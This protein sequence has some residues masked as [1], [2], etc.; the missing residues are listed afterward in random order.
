VRNIIAET[1]D[2]TFPVR[3]V[4]CWGRWWRRYLRSFKENRTS[5]RQ[6]SGMAAEL[7]WREEHGA[8]IIVRAVCIDQSKGGLGLLCRMPVPGKILVEVK[9]QPDGA[10]KPAHLRHCQPFRGAYLLGLQFVR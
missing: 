5:E 4:G 10:G 2:T 7:S 9:L 8:R 1:P 3:T 6:P